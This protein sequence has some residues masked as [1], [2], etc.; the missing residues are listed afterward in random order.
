VFIGGGRRMDELARIVKTRGLDATFRFIPYQ[1]RM[2]LKHSLCVPDVHWISLKPAVEGMI[3]PSKFY[4]IAAAGRPII[5]ITARDGEIAR[6]VLEYKCGVVIE[7]GQADELAK[8]IA[9]LST[10]APS[11]AAMGARA[12]AML[13]AHFTRRQALDRWRDVLD[14]VEQ[15]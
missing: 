5:A 1:D 15:S 10:D 9:D 12:R 11:L 6:L 14:R 3:V 4:G 13:D 2:L 8:A 7:P